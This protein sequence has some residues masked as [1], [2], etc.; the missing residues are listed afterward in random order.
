MRW[1]TMVGFHLFLSRCDYTLQFYLTVDNDW[2][3]DML[4]SFI[5]RY[6][7]LFQVSHH[8][9]M[10]AGHA[11]NEHFTYDIT[12]KLKTKLLGNSVDVYPV[13]RT[14]VTLKKDGV[15]LDL[16]PPLTKVNHLIFGRTWVDSAGEMVMT[17]LTT[18]DKVVLSGRY[19]V[20]AYVY[21]AA[22]EPKIMMTGKWNEKISYQPCDAEGEALP[23]TELKEVWHL[24]DVPKNDKFQYTHFAHKIN[25]FDTAP[26]KLLA[27]D[28]RLRPDRYAL[29]HGDLSKAG[30]EKHSLEERQRA[31][32][33]LQDGFDL[34]VE[35]TSTPW[36]EIE[37]YQ[38]NNKYTEHQNKAESSS[39][40]SSETDLKSIEFNPWQYGNLFIL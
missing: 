13:G 6:L 10:S 35:I 38:Y 32:S 30:A 40:A 34:T 36:G 19:E 15:V 14:R 7:V 33:L 11:E 22:E 17:N 28:S 21:N 18:G 12:S 23:G 8:P 31:R 26:A 25:S 9:P 16:V 37:I 5:I 39:S 4:D 29:E 3:H 2:F 20:D 24:A 27:S 1:P